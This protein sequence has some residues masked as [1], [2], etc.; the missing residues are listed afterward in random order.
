MLDKIG[1]ESLLNALD[2]D[3]VQ[4]SYRYEALRERLIR[5]FL[6]N[7]ADTP[8]ELADETLD[9]LASRL[10]RDHNEIQEP[11]KYASGIARLILQE[12]WRQKNRKQEAL[13][14]ILQEKERIARI[15]QDRSDEE[16][17]ASILEECLESIPE[18][19]R[20]LIQRYYSTESRNQIEQRQ[21]MAAD[22]GI[23]TNALRN[24]AMRIRME[25][26]RKVLMLQA[27]KSFVDGKIHRLK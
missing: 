19:S 5:F 3:R 27:P 8:E 13:A 20:L 24:R 11:A 1:L 17:R 22:Y 10:S 9:R 2:P 4:A 18:P 12:Y 6:W 26:E 15:E 16:E 21:K 7:H 25:L 23:S 14:A